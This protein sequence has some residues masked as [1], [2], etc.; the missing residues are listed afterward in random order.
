MATS[1]KRSSLRKSQAPVICYFC[2]GEE[3][4]WKC[5]DCNVHMC[6]SCK[7]NVHQGLQSVQ[8]HNVVSI[9]DIIESSLGSQ[10]VTS[11]VFSSVLNSYTTTVPVVHT[12]LCSNDNFV[13]FTHFR[14]GQWSENNK[15]VKGKLLKSSIRTMQSF[16]RNIFDMAIN[17]NDEIVF[18]DTDD[19]TIK[20]LSSSGNIKTVLDPSPMQITGIHV[21]RDND[22][23]AGLREKGPVFPA[24]DFSARQVRIFGSDYQRKI[25]F[26]FDKKGNK[27]FTY[28][29]RIRTDSRNIVYA[30]DCLGE[31]NNGRVVAVDI[32][33]RLKFTYDGQNNLGIFKP[34]GITI[35]QSNTIV[36][37]DT[38]NSSIH[39]LNSK[40]QVLGLQ[41]LFD[42]LGIRLSY[43]LCMD[44]EGHLLIGCG[45]GQ[46]EK[47][48]KIHVV[49]MTDS[50]L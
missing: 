14:L 22:L 17:K 32:N 15:F 41:L 39:V 37:S 25:T 31:D 36:V 26:E 18:V 21:N 48:G 46:N 35:T 20:T 16:K 11:V 10:E 4:H 47:Y 50:L 7:V 34:Q 19:T 42:D 3:I 23:I 30:L 8:D 29:F 5:E 33:G 40:G 45:H 24:H 13:Y 38:G 43:S 44:T 2:K 9:Q 6:N 1:M 12:L 28:A 27:L 49:K